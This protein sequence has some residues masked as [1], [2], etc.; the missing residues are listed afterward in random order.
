[1]EIKDYQ[2]IIKK[3]AVFPIKVE[4]FGIAYCYLGIIGETDEATQCSSSEAMKEIG[5]VIW[6]TTALCQQLSLDLE[7]VLS[8]S[9]EIERDTIN[10][11]INS[12]AE[13]VKKHYRDNKVIDK[14]L[15]EDVLTENLCYL[16]D[17]N[18]ISYDD[19]PEIME[20][21]YNKLI[22]RR[23]TNTL[24]GSGDNRENEVKS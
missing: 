6:Y 16:F 1:M 8:L 12:L 14:L 20:L 4:D 15:F 24:H 23:E 3:T 13:H 9:R 18:T 5:D 2:E 17:L 10:L 11:D 19:L 21:N 7:K 22:K